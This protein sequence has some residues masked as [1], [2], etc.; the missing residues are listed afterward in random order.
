MFFKDPG[1]TW[2]DNLQAWATD[3]LL[4]VQHLKNNHYFHQLS[5]WIKTIIC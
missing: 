4:V 1:A 2:L 3:S 5:H